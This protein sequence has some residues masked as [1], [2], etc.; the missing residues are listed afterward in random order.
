MNIG[1]AAVAARLQGGRGGRARLLCGDEL[2][3]PICSLLFPSCTILLH[4]R[5]GVLSR[6]NTLNYETLFDRIGAGK[7]T[8]CRLCANPQI[9]S[10]TM[11]DDYLYGVILET[12]TFSLRLLRVPKT[13]SA[14][15]RTLPRVEP[16]PGAAACAQ[17]RPPV[18]SPSASPL[19]PRVPPGG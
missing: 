3:V 2:S 10:K 6:D 4:P 18:P 9:T 19:P 13:Q 14:R 8:H 17:A 16:Q 15:R 11:R 1:P 5:D 7:T 12:M